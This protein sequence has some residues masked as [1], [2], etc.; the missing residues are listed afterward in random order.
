MTE[1]TGPV[2]AKGLSIG[3]VFPASD[4]PAIFLTPHVFVVVSMHVVHYQR[5]KLETLS[6][7]LALM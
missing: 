5:Y 6:S 1:D 3:P 7:K 2:H 4:L